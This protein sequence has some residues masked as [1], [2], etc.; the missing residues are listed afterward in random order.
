MISGTATVGQTLT[1]STGAWSGTVPI[2]YSY[3][4]AS[5]SS[6]CSTIAGATASSYK[7][8]GADKGSNVSVVVTATNSAGSAQA[9]ARPV[10]PVAEGAPT[11]AQVKAAL[12]KVLKASVRATSTRAIVKA[13]GYKL[14]FTAP[15][16]GEVVIDWFA[17]VKGKQLLIASASVVFRAMG[18]ATAKLE[19]TSKGR[20]LLKAR[21]RLKVTTKATFTPTGQAKISSTTT[22]TLMG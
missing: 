11:P 22:T 1:T 15:S 10:G 5:C 20:K 21:K 13:G 6:S 2:S 14:S 18:T 17:R 19:L 4:W 16:G 3:Q 7:L 12:A 9:A 8:T